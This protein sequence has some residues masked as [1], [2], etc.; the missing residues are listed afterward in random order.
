MK[1]DPI[2]ALLNHQDN[3]YANKPPPYVSCPPQSIDGTV[4]VARPVEYYGEPPPPYYLFW[5]HKALA[6]ITPKRRAFLLI[7]GVIYTLWGLAIISLEVAIGSKFH[8]AYFRS[9]W[10][11]SFIL[12]GGVSM[13]SVSCRANYHKN[14]LIKVFSIALL[15]CV[16]AIIL[17][18]INYG[19]TTKCS[20]SYSREDPC[21]DESVR[22]LK[23]TSLMIIIA[24]S[25][26]A[27]INILVIDYVHKSPNH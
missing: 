25:I 24:A 23:L 17:S 20:K 14:T 7:S 22:N 26:H 18:T 12:S 27:V 15:F 5:T 9:I 4:C 10:T 3:T 11:S 19:T 2:K 21:D 6:K 13:L 1:Q 16:I 8:W